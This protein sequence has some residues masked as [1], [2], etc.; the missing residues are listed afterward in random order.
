M[1]LRRYAADPNMHERL[2]EA[3]LAQRPVGSET[4]S[5]IFSTSA[6]ESVGHHHYP[7]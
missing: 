1:K 3:N 5:S 2:A 7:P 4:M 6:S